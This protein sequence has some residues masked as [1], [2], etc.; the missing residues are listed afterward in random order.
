MN[1]D[2]D[3]YMTK[4]LLSDHEVISMITYHKNI[5]K[6]TRSNLDG[7]GS[8]KNVSVHTSLWWLVDI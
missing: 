6:G 1:A 7:I 5:T 2:D 8:P 4:V 3:D